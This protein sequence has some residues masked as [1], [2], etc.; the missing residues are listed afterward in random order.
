MIR[1]VG[2]STAVKRFEATLPP[3]PIGIEQ[4]ES[5]IRRME[6]D[7]TREALAPLILEQDWLFQAD[8]K[9][10]P[11]RSLKEIAWT[12][13]LAKRLAAHPAKPDVAAELAE[14]ETLR[15][16]IERLPK[17][18]ITAT[19]KELYLA[20]RRVKRS[21]VFKN[22]AV[23]FD[24]IL[25]VEKTE[26]EHHNTHARVGSKTQQDA[27]RLLI[28]QKLRPDGHVIEL[29][30]SHP[31]A[32]MRMDLSFDARRIVVS[33]MPRGKSSYHLYE[34]DVRR[35]RHEP[36][37]LSVS[38]PRQLTDG[39]YD[40]VDPIYLPNGDIVLCTTRGRTSP[41]CVPDSLS[42]ALAR[43][44][45]AGRT[46]RFLSRNSEPD[47]TPALLP[48]GRI[49]YTRWEYS[50][51]PEHH[52][53]K[54][55]TINPDGSGESLYWGNYSYY[56]GMTWEARPIRATSKVMFAGV[57]HHAVIQG[58]VGIIDPYEG[59]DYPKGVWKVTAELPWTEVGDAKRMPN[60]VYSP[61]YHT[62]GNFWGY[63]CPYPLGAEDFLISCS[64]GP[65]NGYRLYLMDVHGNREL[66]YR[67]RK[68]AG[69]LYAQPFRAR[70]QGPQ[71]ADR[72]TLPQPGE[73]ACDGVLYSPNVLSG[74]TGISP[75][76]ARHLRIIQQDYKSQR[77]GGDIWGSPK[78]SLVNTMDAVKRVLGT[79]PIEPDGSV[80]FV[81]PSG[82]AVYF[83]LLDKNYRCLQTMRSFTGVMP[84]ETRGC[85]GCH[86]VSSE[87]PTCQQAGM[88]IAIRKPPATITP[89]PWGA[90]I[91]MGYERLIQPVIDRQCGTCHQGK[92][93]ARKAFDLTLRPTGFYCKA[94]A[95][96]PQQVFKEP[97]VKL[98]RDDNLISTLK[99]YNEVTR[100][101]SFYPWYGHEDSKAY[102]A[103][104]PMSVFSYASPLIYLAM[105]GKHYDV[106]V[107]GSDL[108]LLT[109]WIDCNA[110]YLGNEEI[111]VLQ[112]ALGFKR[113]PVVNRNNVM[114][115]M[116]LGKQ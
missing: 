39:P 43:Y 57:G 14:L 41:R 37:G 12:R 82:I 103:L 85:L 88:S 42:T 65:D 90:A 59:L 116:S 77:V 11:V 60:P 38:A 112:S 19:A 92:G 78:V 80:H 68:S 93:E 33:L 15:K 73:R 98:V 71:L 54:L 91:S 114:N 40:D 27:S 35:H 74:V 99:L 48:D 26:R 62:S 52:H 22:P 96:S 8:Y 16:R 109:A 64:M 95:G 61:D 3:G 89:P 31:G 53:F 9:P 56:P 25:L 75:K 55:W 45:R 21:I 50:D 63:R 32:V 28:L 2:N 18:V 47:Y 49:L 67:G 110:V 102:E 115:A 66:I 20:V 94:A 108:R 70:P 83:Q 24:A 5:T 79:V 51:R 113:E 87:S 86:S 84:G 72:T 69:V 58:V 104:P 111:R 13:E 10:T 101:P 23:D 100:W 1:Y 29:L 76:Q 46:I 107:E 105:S 4:R 6:D 81:V 30:P 106:K 17:V 7:F 36:I 34:I 44:D 97:Y